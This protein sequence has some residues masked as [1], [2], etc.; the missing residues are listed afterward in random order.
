MV[1]K[2]RPSYTSSFLSSRN[3]SMSS[4][5]SSHFGSMSLSRRRTWVLDSMSGNDLGKFQGMLSFASDTISDAIDKMPLNLKRQ[6]ECSHHSLEINPH[7]LHFIPRRTIDTLK[8]STIR[9]IHTIDLEHERQYLHEKDPLFPFYLYFSALITIAIM[10]IRFL[11]LYDEHTD[12]GTFWY[13]NGTIVFYLTVSIIA[14]SLYFTHKKKHEISYYYRILIWASISFSLILIACLDVIQCP[15][16]NRITQ[17]ER[18]EHIDT[19]H[20]GSHECLYKWSRYYTYLAVLALT[21][22]SMFMRINLWLKFILGT[23]TLIIV[24]TLTQYHSCSVFVKI[25]SFYN[26]QNLKEMEFFTPRL[27]HMQYLF[28][29]YLMFYVMDRQIEYI[30][31][32]DFLWSVKLKRERQEARITRNV[33]QLLLKNMLPIHVA[34]RYLLNTPDPINNTELYYEAYN[35]IAVMF[36]SIPNFFKFYR[37]DDGLKYLEILN[38]I[39]CDFDRLLVVPAFSHKIEKIKTVG[40]TYMAASGLRPGKGSIDSVISVDEE[41]ENL[42]VLIRFAMAMTKALKKFNVHRNSLYESGS[43]VDFKLRIGIAMGAV[44][45]GVVGSVKPQYDI[46]GD[47]VN[48]ASRMDT[49][50][51]IDRIHTTE[52]VGKILIEFNFPYKPVCRGAMNIKGKG[53]MSTY[54]ID[55]NQKVMIEEYLGFF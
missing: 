22:I 24:N 44:T 49:N 17:E 47:T 9:H 20:K 32:L 15:V 11:T 55:S 50:G 45:A 10:I 6:Y 8:K 35:S 34:E 42:I 4:R 3:S 38:N 21:S 52:E 26:H 53:M 39:I 16:S 30:M 41:I 2:P 54:L 5:S 13:T 46:W 14:I 29:V 1:D 12:W 18:V 25:D 7:L 43:D 31:R 23:I 48:V 27:A 33:N 28:V 37:D 40:S 51:L 36:A 19:S